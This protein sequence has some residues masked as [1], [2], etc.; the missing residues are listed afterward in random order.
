MPAATVT[1]TWSAVSFAAAEAARDSSAISDS[2]SAGLTATTMK[3]A[4]STASPTEV[5][6]TE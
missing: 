4:F 5:T 2:T 3:V 6:S 1:N